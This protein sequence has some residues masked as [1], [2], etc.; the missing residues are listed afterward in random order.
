M[1]ALKS[2][3]EYIIPVQNDDR[4]INYH[5]CAKCAK[6]TNMIICCQ[7]VPCYI[8][9]DEIKDLSYQGICNLI[10]TGLVS[11]DWWDEKV[12]DDGTLDDAPVTLGENYGKDG[13]RSY[14]LRMRGKNAPV[15][16]PCIFPITCVAY[17][18]KTGCK[19][20]FTHRPKG[21]RSLLPPHCTL[22]PLDECVEKYTKKRCAYEWLKYEDV[23]K[24]AF[25]KYRKWYDQGTGFNGAFDIMRMFFKIR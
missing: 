20:P 17:D 8:S 2:F 25:N 21:G 6:N 13:Y 23:L 15:V 18:K 4:M 10:E 14:F 24:Q 5:E 11:I 9:P 7:N 16:H 3:K 22:N 12:V 19:L 1:N